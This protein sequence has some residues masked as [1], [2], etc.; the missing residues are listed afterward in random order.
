AR[1]SGSNGDVGY[2]VQAFHKGGEGYRDMG[3]QMTDAFAK[4]RFATGSHGDLMAKIAFHDEFARTT[5]TGLTDELYSQNPR[6]NTVAPDDY[7]AIRRYEATLQHEQRLAD[8][9]KLRTSTFAYHMDFGLRLQD[10][11]RARLPDIDYVRI[12]DPTGLFFRN[13][14]SLRDRQY[15]VAGLSEEVEAGSATPGC[16]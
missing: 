2:V 13:T 14:T 4:A 6:A 9:V 11:D 16:G 12:P 5:Y 7:F 8:N 15:N 1:Y 10:F 3:F